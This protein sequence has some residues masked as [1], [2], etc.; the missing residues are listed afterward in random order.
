[1]AYN[2]V[3]EI[4]RIGSTETPGKAEDIAFGIGWWTTVER[5]FAESSN[6][7]ASV[8]D[9]VE[10]AAGGEGIGRDAYIQVSVSG[11]RDPEGVYR[12]LT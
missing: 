5:L 9:Q 1:M 2:V 6:P 7:A 11:G 3:R 8:S 4:Y 12:H 10:W